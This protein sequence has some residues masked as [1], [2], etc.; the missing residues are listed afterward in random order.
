MRHG[1]AI[2][3]MAAALLAGA[4]ATAR[5]QG[6]GGEGRQRAGMMG[7]PQRM[8]QMLF[9]GIELS[10]E[11]KT[12][13]EKVRE[14]FAPRLQKLRDE[15]RAARESGQRSPETM[16][17]AMRKMTAVNREQQDSLRAVLTEA[18][19]PAFDKNVT[20]MQTRRPGGAGR[21]PR[22]RVD[23]DRR[24]EAPRRRVDA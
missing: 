18:Q 22:A 8:E 11:Q 1:L 9:E 4:S 24:D 16:Q 21:P 15:A 5:A 17:E 19:R 3:V 7:N 6:G 2:T 14:L 12:R 13:V 20:E 10:A 23:D